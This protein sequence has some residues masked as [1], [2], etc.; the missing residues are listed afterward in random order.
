MPVGILTVLEDSSAVFVVMVEVFMLTCVGGLM[1]FIRTVI[2]S[3]CKT[4]QTRQQVGIP[5]T[6]ED[7]LKPTIH[8][9][10]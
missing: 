2:V 4:T 6:N 10:H 7:F 3:S 5:A 1:P 9:H 8:A